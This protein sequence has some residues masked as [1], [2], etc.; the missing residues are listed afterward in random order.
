MYD[1]VLN[2]WTELYPP[3]HIVRFEG[4][5]AGPITTIITIMDTRKRF[6]TIRGK[7]KHATYRAAC[8]AAL[9]VIE[10]LKNGA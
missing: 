10:E 1:H 9:N 6:P 2:C 8:E 3:G 5:E 4:P 7:I